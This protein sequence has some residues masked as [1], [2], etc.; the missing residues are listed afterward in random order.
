MERIKSK[1]GIVKLEVSSHHKKSTIL[2][3]NTIKWMNLK[4]QYQMKALKRENSKFYVKLQNIKSDYK[5]K[6]D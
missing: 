6:K 4:R 3:D 1:T 2:S 5:I